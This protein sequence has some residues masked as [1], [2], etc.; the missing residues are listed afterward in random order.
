MATVLQRPMFKLGGSSDGVGIT[1]GFRRGYADGT[2]SEKE[3]LE[4]WERENL[5]GIG[6]VNTQSDIEIIESQTDNAG[7]MFNQEISDIYEQM[8]N[9]EKEKYGKP[10][11]LWD[12]YRTS[13]GAT[14]WKDWI[15]GGADLALERRDAK[16]L[17][18]KERPGKLFE[19]A[20]KGGK[21]ETD[22]LKATTDPQTIA[23][24][25]LMQDVMTTVE[26]WKRDNPGATINDFLK[27]GNIFKID[28]AMR[29]ANPEWPGVTRIR[30]QIEDSLEE[31]LARIDKN[32]MLP[33]CDPDCQ[34]KYRKEQLQML[35]GEYL[36][37]QGNA[38]GGKPT[39]RRGY[40]LGMGPAMDQQTDMSM[41]ENIQTPQGDMSMTENVDMTQMGQQTGM[42]AQTTP[43]D[44]PFVLL[45]ARLPKEISDDVVRLI[46]YN[47]E[48][49]AD[50]A[51]IE[52]QDDVIAFNK[53]YGVELVVNT[54][55]VSGAIA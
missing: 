1:S 33:R 31:K 22:Y 9:P 27:S 47:P 37:F 32:T 15:T 38:M 14:D 48:A 53:K 30:R 2:L 40:N 34:D 4:K 46:A 49:F 45:R 41:T 6:D 5:S 21:A 54:D 3:E 51:D 36:G 26:E 24:M 42:P 23:R 50:F 43:T 11:L 29:S 7:G 25:N 28:S 52:T 13:K 19:M 39:D 10:D 35:I 20:L 44:D 18:D 55:E 17:E 8:K 12:M 16:K